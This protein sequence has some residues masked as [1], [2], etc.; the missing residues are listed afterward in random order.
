MIFRYPGNEQAGDVGWVPSTVVVVK[1]L[2]GGYLAS[3]RRD[4][5]H[6]VH[7]DAEAAAGMCHRCTRPD[8]PCVTA[9][10]AGCIHRWVNPTAFRTCGC[11]R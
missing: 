3:G 11:D 10:I 6:G 7:L 5:R 2:R 9:E 4:R 8:R 1:S